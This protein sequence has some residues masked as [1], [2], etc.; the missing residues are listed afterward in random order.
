[1]STLLVI[2]LFVTVPTLLSLIFVPF[3]IVI[4]DDDFAEFLCMF[5]F[6]GLIC[7]II[8]GIIAIFI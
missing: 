6:F 4:G 3:F 1:M 2:L 7:I 5:A 8:L